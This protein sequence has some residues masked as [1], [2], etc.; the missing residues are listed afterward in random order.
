MAL[1]SALV[2]LIALRVGAEPVSMYDALMVPASM[3]R[4]IVLALRLPRVMLACLAG[5]AL[6]ASGA[7]LQVTLRNPLAEPFVLGVSGGA[8]L[9]ASLALL[10]G[11]TQ[12]GWLGALLLPLAA[13][14]GGLTATALVLGWARGRDARV[15]ALLAG[16][17]I[18]AIASA[19]ITFLKSAVSPQRAQAMMFWLTGFL[20]VPSSRA[21]SVL[22]M[23]VAVGLAGLLWIAPRLNLLALGEESAAALGVDVPRVTRTSLVLASLLTGAVVSLT[24][25]I[26]FVGLVVPHVLRRRY[27]PDLRRLLPASA[28][29]GACLLVV[30]D[31]VSRALFMWL[32]TEVPVGA[33]TALLGG[34][35][36]LVAL[37]RRAADVAT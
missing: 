9:G 30:C 25:L 16:V 4:T 24:G 3:D 19:I 1:A 11:L 35:F 13:L 23:Y 33:I 6:S 26:G 29:M 8:A 37:R 20:D 32:H 27:G 22:A 21:L 17:A 5:A 14:L 7:S 34:P 36:F 31:A 10:L 15:T 12:D 18:N 2:F 28:L